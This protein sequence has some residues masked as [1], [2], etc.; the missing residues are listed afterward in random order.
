MK[1][2]ALAILATL[3]AGCNS[4]GTTPFAFAP[5]AERSS[6]VSHF[7]HQHSWVAPDAKR[8]DLLYI[9][10]YGTYE[11]SVFSYPE[12]KLKGM[13]SGFIGPYGECADPSGHVY[14][15]IENPPSVLEYAHGGTKPI[16][17]IA[18]PG[19]Y[20][21]SCSYDPTSGDLAVTNEYSQSSTPGSV[22]IYRRARG[23]PHNYT[24]SGTAVTSPSATS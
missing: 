24:E 22:S 6:V 13:L 14:I 7:A 12:G 18:D 15:A 16:A 19:Q 1:R 8:H 3:V 10:D 11:V 2:S 9:S 20:P 17:T 4:A 21:Y 23:E 5:S